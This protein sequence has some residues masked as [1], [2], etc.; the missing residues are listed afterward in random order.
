MNDNSSNVSQRP[1]VLKLNKSWQ[2]VQVSVVQ[3][4]IVDLVS[5]VV[6]ALDIEYSLREDGS[7]D[8]NKY[9][10]VNPV[11]WETWMT[12]PI[13]PWDMVIHSSKLSIRVPTVVITKKYNK[14]PTK[15]YRGKPTRE[16]LFYRDGGIDIYTGKPLVYE[17]STI[18]HIIPRFH[19]GQDTF[20]NTGLTT[21]KINNDKGNKLNSDVGL[22][23]KFKPTTPKEVPVWKTI[24]KL[25]HD[26]W[27]F[28]IKE[29]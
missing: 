5:G 26:D 2:P 9:E 18:D 12:L 8:T 17:N 23:L 20:E 11:S 25:K 27:K 28:F 4:I 1:I 24:R 7:P 3:D 16:A 14:M 22:K 21:K 10:Y 15:K 6:D 29:N 13:R 19:G